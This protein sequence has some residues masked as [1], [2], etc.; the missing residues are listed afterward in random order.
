MLETVRDCKIS[1]IAPLNAIIINLL[2]VKRPGEV[3]IDPRSSRAGGGLLTTPPPARPAYTSVTRGLYHGGR[4]PSCDDSCHSSTVIP[5]TLDKPNIMKRYYLR[6]TCCHTSPRR[7]PTMVTLHDTRFV[8]CR[9]WNDGWTVKTNHL[10]VVGLHDTDP[11][12]E[13]KALSL[14]VQTVEV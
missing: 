2:R 6:R 7:S 12:I 14:P 8:E 5:P 4:R 11:S 9:R 10:T 3:G 13:R 1:R